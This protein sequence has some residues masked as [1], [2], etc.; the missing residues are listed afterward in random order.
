[1]HAGKT[2]IHV[3][4]NVKK[5]QNA[6]YTPS[7]LVPFVGKV[8][9]LETLPSSIVFSLLIQMSGFFLVQFTKGQWARILLCYSLYPFVFKVNQEKLLYVDAWSLRLGHLG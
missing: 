7:R 3:K 8:V 5:F 4:K 1:M 6:V 9:F 2:L